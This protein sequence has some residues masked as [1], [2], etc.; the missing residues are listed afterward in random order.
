VSSF[1]INPVQPVWCEAKLYHSKMLAD[2]IVVIH[3]LIVLFILAG[4]P[5]IYLGVALR[6]KWV[7]NW[8]WRMLTSVPSCS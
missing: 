8:R 1:A 5:L 2:A 4:P 3:L 7:K 6:W